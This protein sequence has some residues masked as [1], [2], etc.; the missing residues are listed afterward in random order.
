MITH[1]TDTQKVNWVRIIAVISTMVLMLYA[2]KLWIST[3]D[4]PVVPLFDWLP[5]AYYPFDYILAIG[6]FLIQIVYI[7]KPKRWI[8]VTVLLLYLYLAFTD[9]NRLQPYFYQSFLTIFA[10][11]IF[12]DKIPIKK[13]LYA[14]ILIFFATYFWSG[15]Q[16]INGIFYIQWMSALQKHF[17]FIPEPLLQFFTYCVPWLEA[18]MG[19]LL[20]FNK[21]RKFIV[22]FIVLMHSIIIFLL[23]YLGY[24]YNVVPWNVQNILSVII[25]FWGLKTAT[26][27][28]FFTNHFSYQ[29]GLIIF[30]TILLP[31]SNLFGVYDH[32]LSFSFFTS[33]LKYYN[34]IISEE[35]EEKLPEHIQQYYRFYDEQ[36]Y[37]NMNEWAGDVNKVLF[38]PEDRAILYMD[39]YLRSFADDPTK[40]ELTKLVVY[41]QDTQQK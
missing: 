13:V 25:L 9:Q 4:F 32:L 16:K 35:L 1:L 36:T 19:V 22:A 10:I 18:A 20:L 29:K 7:F 24:G 15:I 6:F 39:S 28:E 38:Y 31:I 27:H 33:K 37:L 11:V 2:P 23:F 12:K 14:I 21:T 34:V 41:N 3:K 8:G 5:V 40:K 30:F 17:S 26:F